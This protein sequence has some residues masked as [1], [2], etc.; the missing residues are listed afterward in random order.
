MLGRMWRKE[1]CRWEWKLMPSPWKTVWRVLKKKKKKRERE[2]YYVIQQS[3][4]WIHIQRKENYFLEDISALLCSL[5]Y[6]NNFSIHQWINEIY[7]YTHEYNIYEYYSTTRKK[8][9]LSFVARVE[10]EGILLSY[11]SHIETNTA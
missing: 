3:H 9:T 4:F 5:S 10:L 8:K 1:Q 6:G 11:V 7:I 2:N